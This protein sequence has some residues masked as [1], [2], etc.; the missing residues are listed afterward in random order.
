MVR[1]VPQ[2]SRGGMCQSA[3]LVGSHGRLSALQDVQLLP[4]GEDIQI[5]GL[6]RRA[7][8]CEECES[9]GKQTGRLYSTAISIH[10]V[11][12]L[13]GR[14]ESRAAGSFKLLGGA[15]QGSIQTRG[16]PGAV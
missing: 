11:R 7:Q 13:P 3:P 2:G 10:R 16:W 8:E 14:T 12:V 4:Q 1:P 9:Q 15:T 5:L 6:M